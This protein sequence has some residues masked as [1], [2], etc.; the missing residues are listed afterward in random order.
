[1]MKDKL[2]FYEQYQ[3]T[4]IRC[5]SCLKSNH[6]IQ[7]CPY[8]HYIPDKNFLINRYNYSYSQTRKKDFV[9]KPRKKLKALL[10]LEAIDNALEKLWEDDD[11]E[12][13]LA[14]IENELFDE[15]PSIEENCPIPLKTLPETN[16]PEEDKET[17]ETSP[18]KDFVTPLPIRGSNTLLYS[19]NPTAVK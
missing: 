13:S 18:R 5:S 17:K 15:R 11:F 6:L 2:K 19:K 3:Y 12:E 9:R 14:G 8:I 10:Q 1:M 7:T 4:N 16:E